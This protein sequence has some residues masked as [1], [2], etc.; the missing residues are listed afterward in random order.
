MFTVIAAALGALGT[1][2]SVG[3][4]A[5]TWFNKKP[6]QSATEVKEDAMLEKAANPPGDA[7]VDKRLHDGKF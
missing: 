1:L 6:D 7:D 4:G 3:W 5:Y 2:V